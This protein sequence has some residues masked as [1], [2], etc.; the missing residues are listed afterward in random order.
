MN[1]SDTLD[2]QTLDSNMRRIDLCSVRRSP[3]R[4]LAWIL[5]LLGA[6]D[7]GALQLQ[8]DEWVYPLDIAV[9]NKQQV[10]VADRKL[11]GVWRIQDGKAHVVIQGAKRFRQPLNAVWSVAIDQQGQ[12]LVGDSATRGVYRL[13]KEG[14]AKKINDSYIGIPI[15]MAVDHQGRIY[16]SDL[17]TERIWRL[18]PDGGKAEQFAAIAGVRGLAIDKQNRLWAS[19]ANPPQ[20]VRYTPEGEREIIVDQ[21]PFE[22]PHQLVVDQESETAYVADGY[23]KCIWKIP[24][25]GDPEKWIT[26]QPLI[27]PTGL[28]WLQK[29]LLIVDPKAKAIFKADLQGTLT[30]FHPPDRS[31]E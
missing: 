12:V 2:R 14:E 23:A 20:L 21:G 19:R 27:G 13:S 24:S 29:N 11:P 15:R 1:D 30:P 5:V 28:A 17:E 26:G 22:F 25:Q 8:A 6:A 4:S 18:P 31:T 9:D 7:F 16:V 10:F 3:D